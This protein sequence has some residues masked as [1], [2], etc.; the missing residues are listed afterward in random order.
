MLKIYTILFLVLITSCSSKSSH[1]Y[2]KEA[3]SFFLE[4]DYKH[5]LESINEAIHLDS[6]NNEHFSLRARIYSE[7]ADTIHF[8]EDV[9]HVLQVDSTD[10]QRDRHLRQLINWETHINDSEAKELI[11][12]ELALFKND[13]AQHLEVVDYVVRQY[14]RTND[15]VHAIELCE[16]TI[17]DYPDK[18]MPY[19]HLASIELTRLDFRHAVKHYRQYVEIDEQNDIVYS[20]LAY[21]YI[22]LNNKKR[23]KKYYKLAAELG[24]EEACKQFRELS[25]KTRYRVRSVCCDGSTSSSTGR[26]TCSHHGGVCDVEYIPYKEYNWSCNY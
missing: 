1:D 19:L 13:T 7:L 15:T 17:K 5:A 23:A 26:G 21:C 14:L 3:F 12:S 11:K 4:E 22:Q 8:Q 20:N 18:A 6:L 2:H 24:N 10:S 25:A 16:A 9:N